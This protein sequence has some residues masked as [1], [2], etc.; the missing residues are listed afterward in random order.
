MERESGE[1]FVHNLCKYCST[2]SNYTNMPDNYGHG[3]TIN[4]ILYYKVKVTCSLRELR[5]A[6]PRCPCIGK[7]I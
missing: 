6:C 5:E 4:N 3:S 7:I 1:L 2:A